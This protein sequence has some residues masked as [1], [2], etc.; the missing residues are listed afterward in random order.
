MED[1]FSKD[2]PIQD[3]IRAELGGFWLVSDLSSTQ[4]DDISTRIE[5]KLV[6]RGI[7]KRVLIYSQHLALAG[8][9][10]LLVLGIGWAAN[11]LSPSNPEPPPIETVIVTKIVQLAAPTRVVSTPAPVI[12]PAPLSPGASESAVRRRMLESARYWKNLWVDALLIQHGP[13]G[14]VGAPLIRHEQVWVSQPQYSLVLSAWANRDVDHVWYAADGKVYD[15][16][17]ST[18]RPRL[19]DYHDDHLPVYSAL[20]SFIFPAQIAKEA[21]RLK[22]TGEDQVAGREALI[23]DWFST[24]EYRIGRL[25]VDTET[26]IVLRWRQFQNGSNVVTLEVEMVSLILD[27]DFPRG[28]FDR[29]SLT[30]NFAG[31]ELDD[32]GVRR[33]ALTRTLVEPPPGHRTLDKVP[34]PDGFDPSQSRLAFQWNQTPRS[35]YIQPYLA[36]NRS[37]D[38]YGEE[39]P[40]D[41]FADGYYLGEIRLNP[42]SAICDRSADGINIA[43]ISKSGERNEGVS[44]L[45]WI[46]LFDLSSVSMPTAD[47]QIGWDI[48]FAPDNNRLAYQGCVGHQCGIHVLDLLT[49]E[50][51]RV[52]LQPGGYLTWNPEGD[53]L[54]W[55][56]YLSSRR[57]PGVFVR[58][59]RSGAVSYHGDVDDQ[60]GELPEE[61][62]F[63]AWGGIYPDRTYGMEGCVAS[64]SSAGSPQANVPP[65]SF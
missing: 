61:S 14:Y 20:E 50:S 16:E 4:L 58:D 54:A 9:V 57:T 6:Q 49:G 47:I 28:T 39:I 60:T 42:W 38:D 12:T 31:A 24:N 19:Y 51:E 21:H 37:P 5:S 22:V 10:T 48:A 56:G 8:L 40:V 17:L 27:A 3:Q 45:K 15:V 29:K 64:P 34:P 36:D 33:L 25:W 1:E 2:L 62:L 46:N 65:G 59:M 41:V 63:T 11:M 23:L 35:G 52:F 32:P 55:I 44:S 13:K 53:Q 26:G 43:Y 7:R 18:G 30:T